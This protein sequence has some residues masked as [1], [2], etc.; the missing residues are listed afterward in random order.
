M[1]ADV[2]YVQSDAK[3]RRVVTRDSEALACTSIREL[4]EQLD[5]ERYWRIHRARIVSLSH[6]ASVKRDAFGHI[7]VRL[8]GRDEHS[9]SANRFSRAFASCEGQSGAQR[10]TENSTA[11]LIA[12]TAP[13][14]PIAVGVYDSAKPL[15]S[16]M[17]STN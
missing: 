17:R 11:L 12:Y 3:H 9:W 15:V 2:P 10:P 4:A 16:A 1:V 5:P 14:A 7:D 6:I 8:N 13:S